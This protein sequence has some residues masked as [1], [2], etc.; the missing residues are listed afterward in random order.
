[1]RSLFLALILP[2]LV[3]PQRAP[4]RP[5]ETDE[6]SLYE[7]LAPDSASF[8]ILYEVTAID[9]GATVFFNPIRKGSAASGESVRDRA[10]SQ[11][12]QFEQ[13][14]GEEARRSGLPE[15]ELDTEL[16]PH[17]PAAPGAAG[18]RRPAAD[19][20]DLQGPEELPA[21]GR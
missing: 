20:E 4:E 15:A 14:S 1:M 19:R 6:Y 21:E 8:H 17:P 9:P 12:L 16:H 2:L 18:R 10:T 11:P 3:L 13:V 5:T 7:L